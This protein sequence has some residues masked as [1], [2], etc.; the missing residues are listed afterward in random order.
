MRWSFAAHHRDYGRFPGV[1]AIENAPPSE[2]GIEEFLAFD[3]PLLGTADNVW[4]LGLNEC[5]V[6]GE[7]LLVPS[8]DILSGDRHSSTFD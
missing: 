3:T 4:L 7:R 2:D 8:L 6:G 5:M 1:N